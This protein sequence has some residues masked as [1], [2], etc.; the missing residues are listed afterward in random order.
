MTEPRPLCY[1]FSSYPAEKLNDNNNVTEKHRTGHQ[2]RAYDPRR[3]ARMELP[4]ELTKVISTV[5]FD[6]QA[7]I[8]FNK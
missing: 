2:R 6:E 1:L 8:L 7:Y 4:D 3:I 5:L